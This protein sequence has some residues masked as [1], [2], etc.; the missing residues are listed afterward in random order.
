LPLV[1]VFPADPPA[2]EVAGFSADLSRTGGFDRD[3]FYDSFDQGLGGIY[4]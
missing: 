4:A 1:T 2:L 3:G